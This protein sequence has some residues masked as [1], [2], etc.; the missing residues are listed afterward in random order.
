MVLPGCL[1]L[2]MAGL[3]YEKGLAGW[4]P[5]FGMNP[6]GTPSLLGSQPKEQDSGLI[7]PSQSLSELCNLWL[8]ER[9]AGCDLWGVSV[10]PGPG[11]QQRSVKSPFSGGCEE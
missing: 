1:H 10:L 8:W 6:L 3:G 9:E 11:H 2:P 7:S 5:V 4:D